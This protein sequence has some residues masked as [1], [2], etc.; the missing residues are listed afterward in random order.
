MGTVNITVSDGV[1]YAVADEGPN[2]SEAVVCLHGFTGSKQSW[3]FLDEML[4]DSRLIKI[5]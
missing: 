4:S 1:R 5:D 3:T 2:A